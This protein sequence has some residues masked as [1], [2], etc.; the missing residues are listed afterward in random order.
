[1]SGRERVFR[2]E[3][4][5]LRR[6]DL[7]EA[8]RLVVAYAP[9]HGKMRLVAKGVRRLKSRKAG[10]L[11]PFTRVRLLVARGRELNVITQAESLET[12]GALRRDLQRLGE[13]SY[14]VELIDRFTLDEAG[15]RETYGL[16]IDTLTRLAEGRPGAAVLRFFELRLLEEMGYRPEFFRCVQCGAEVRPEAQAFAPVLGGVICPTCR[17]R[18]PAARPLGLEALKV[19]RHTSRSGFEAAA[20]PELRPAV[21]Q[22]VEGHLEAYLTHLLERTLNSPRFLRQIQALET[23]ESAAPA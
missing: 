19:L 20:A 6:I 11:E 17:R 14:V 8:D 2:T 13:A 18:H 15:S 22:E 3:A 4:V 5:V 21:R 23:A 10:H 12:F 9:D 1:M 16:L 7:G